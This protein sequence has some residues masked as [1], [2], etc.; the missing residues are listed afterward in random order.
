MGILK[1]FLGLDPSHVQLPS[2]IHHVCD[3]AGG[4]CLIWFR[5]SQ[6]QDVCIE[7]LPTSGMAFLIFLFAHLSSPYMYL[8]YT[9]IW[10]VHITCRGFR[11]KAVCHSPDLYIGDVM[12]SRTAGGE[13]GDAT[14]FLAEFVCDFVPTGRGIEV[15]W[16]P[17]HTYHPQYPKTYPQDY[18]EDNHLVAQILVHI[19]NS[20]VHRILPGPH[21]VR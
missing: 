20:I 10:K 7:L 12:G 16:V 4:I 14:A 8:A 15:I 17:G 9:L 5:I 19:L 6:E 13:I 18:H 11:H 21:N 1:G 3:L 2:Q